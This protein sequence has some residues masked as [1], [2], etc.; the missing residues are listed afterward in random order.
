MAYNALTILPTNFN[1]SKRLVLLLTL[2]LSQFPVFGAEKTDKSAKKSDD[3]ALIPAYM[4]CGDGKVDAPRRRPGHPVDEYQL[5]PCEDGSIKPWHQTIELGPMVPDRWRIVE[6][7]GVETDLWNP[8]DGHNPIK[9]DMPIW[10]DDWFYSLIAISDTVVEPRNIPLPVGNATT[11][12]PDSLDTIGHGDSTIFSQTLIFEHVIYQGDT[13]FRP[14]DYEFRLTTALNYNRVHTDERGLL[15]VDPNLGGDAGRRRSDNFLG[16]QAAFVDKH[17]RNVSHR[18]DFDSLR[19]GIQPF[20]SDFRGFLFQDSQLGIR[21]FG[22]RDNNIFQYNLAWFRRLEKDSNSGL[23]DL[24]QNLRDD[25]VFTANLYWQDFPSLGFTS[26]F[27]VTYNK[28]REQGQIE[29]DKNGFIA[30]PASIFEERFARDY[31]ITYLGYSGDGHFG[32]LNVTGSAYYAF[33]QQTNTRY[34]NAQDE[35]AAFFFATE[36]SMDFDW[37]RPKLSLLWASGDSDPFDGIAT[38]F[39]AIFE[40]PQFAGADT[41]FFIRQNVPLIG[42]GGIA[43]SGRNGILPS[44][45]SSKEQGQSNFINPGLIL[46]GL[47]F[48]ADILPELRVSMNVNQLWF[49]DTAVLESLRQQGDID[50]NLGQD[51]SASLI[52]RPYQSQNIVLRF[53]AAALVPGSGLDDLYGSDYVTPYSVLANLIL[54]Y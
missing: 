30:R 54:T 46:F 39:D 25:D 42:G 24:S 43:L 21:L 12:R 22:N 15:N 6:A 23:N 48:D 53:S 1:L 28:N 38:G 26:Q 9:G 13:V 32:R 47:G 14:P 20:S 45:R 36:T 3:L 37:L 31:D 11:T 33:G 35:V 16:I 19:V 41:S 18:Y 2:A 34:R 10:G 29:Y 49:D 52:W 17:L 50:N 27:S 4:M 8:Y 7:L 51:I 44:L 5:Q 40:N